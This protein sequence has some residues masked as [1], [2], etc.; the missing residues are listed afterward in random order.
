MAGPTIDIDFTKLDCVGQATSLLNAYTKALTG[1]QRI[2]VRHD[3]YWTS[4]KPNTPAEMTM[5]RNLYQ[6]IRAQCPA[7]ANLP[8]L[9]P[10]MRVRRGPAL[11]LKIW[12]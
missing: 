1:G 6:L 10:G 8:D 7:A 4:Y 9:S 5:L 2:Q 12:G 11:P 3:T